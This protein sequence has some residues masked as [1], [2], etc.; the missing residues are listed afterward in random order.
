V[1]RKVDFTAVPYS[2]MIVIDVGEIVMLQ[3]QPLDILIVGKLKNSLGAEACSV[4]EFLVLLQEL[5]TN[6]GWARLGYASLFDFCHLGLNLTRAES[7]SRKINT[8]G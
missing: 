1:C 8:G 3:S 7:Y 6:R 2:L 5:D 4:A